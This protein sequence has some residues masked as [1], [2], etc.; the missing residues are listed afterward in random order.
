MSRV[1]FSWRRLGL[2]AGNTLREAVRQ[3]LFPGLLLVAVALVASVRFFGEFNFGTSELKFI[4]DFGLGAVVVFGS[5]LSLAAT[6]QLFFAEIEH[7]TALTL[8][9]RPVWR[10]E[11]VFGKLLGV[12]AVVGL[13]CVVLTVLLVGLLAWRESALMAQFP[14]AFAAG[15]HV[16]YGGVIVAG[17]LQGLKFGV[18]IAFTLLIASYARSQLFTVMAGFLVLAICHLQYLGRE[19]HVNGL[20]GP[21]RWVAEGAA[22]LFP[23]FQVFYVGEFLVTGPGGVA[24][25]ADMILRVTAYG[26]VYV[27]V[28]G[29]LAV[30]SFRSREL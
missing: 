19:L 10:A 15:R 8:L 1:A 20:A 21:A 17:A 14:E 7:R 13:F 11:F 27:L 9:A 12:W 5:I 26:L 22:V 30:V 23:N 16:H 25:G 29:G 18:L 4:A 6:A 3:R 24:L 2:I 28:L